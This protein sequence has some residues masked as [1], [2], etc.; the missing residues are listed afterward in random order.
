MWL[1]KKPAD[2]DLETKEILDCIK[3]EI[4]GAKE[5]R[6]DENILE[7][8]QPVSDDDADDHPADLRAGGVSVENEKVEDD[9]GQFFSLIKDGTEPEKKPANVEE[10]RVENTNSDTGEGGLS[11]NSDI[12]SGA[13]ERI[14]LDA[15]R[16][17]LQQWMGENLP[18][19]IQA[20]VVEP[21]LKEW[22]EANLSAIVRNVVEERIDKI[23]QKL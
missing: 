11:S 3:A 8:V 22:I 15:L 20:A 23:F 21:M 6:A 18:Q 1:N 7:L 4:V 16:P 13:L 17:A 2:K 14:F 12:D 10:K 9:I 19:L 5:S